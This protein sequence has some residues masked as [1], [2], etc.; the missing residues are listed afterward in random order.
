MAR[1]LMSPHRRYRFWPP[2]TPTIGFMGEGAG[3]A[4]LTVHF[5]NE[6]TYAN[7]YRWEFSDGSVRSDDNPVHV[8]H[9]P[10]VYDVTFYVE[11]YEGTELVKVHS[12][13]V[14]VFPTAQATF[15]LSPNHAIVPG[16]TVY[17]LNLSENA[18][19]YAWDLG[20]GTT[21]MVESSVHEYL[22]P[23]VYDVTLT[24]NNVWGCVRMYT[25]PEVVV[26]EAGG[27]VEFP[28]AFTPSASGSNGGYYDPT[29]YDN[30][31]FRPLHVG[32]ES[33]ELMVFTKW[34]EMIFTRTT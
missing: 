32:V 22:E 1:A 33:Y 13:V 8:L 24:A 31:V 20:D 11:G 25:L 34:G 16:Q 28:S 17:C 10:G 27:H 6:S 21:S 15:T 29:S 18:T 30:D 23:G 9:E 14:E 2:P 19:I 7:S 4:P 12:A 5:N 3:C 26:A